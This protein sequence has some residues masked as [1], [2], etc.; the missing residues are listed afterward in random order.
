MFLRGPSGIGKS[1]VVYQAAKFLSKHVEDWRG[2]KD[3]RLSQMQPYDLLGVPAADIANE[4]AKMCKFDSV[5]PQNGAGILF[6]DEINAA[7]P[8]M[9]AAAYQLLLTPQDFGIPPEWMLVA[10][11]NRKSDRGVVVNMAAPMI[12][13]MCVINVGTTLDDFR[14]HAVKKGKRPEMTSFL[15]DR[16]DFLHKMDFPSGEVG[17]FPNPRSWFAVSDTLDV[18]YDQQTRTELVC[19]DVGEE[20]GT[21]FEAHLRVFGEAPRIDD[22]LEGKPVSMPEKMDV[23]YC[24]AMGLAARLSG[25]NFDTAYSFVEKMPAEVSTLTIKLA[26]KRDKTLAD[27]AAFTKWSLANQKAFSRV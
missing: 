27:A 2:V 18:E 12:A 16:P 7:P 1:E 6:L 4:I 15:S 19:G 24:V 9:Q 25:E 20:A 26:Y 10:A 3:L 22:I 13:R 23:M 5:T 21:S 8:V 14:E 11:G 17:P